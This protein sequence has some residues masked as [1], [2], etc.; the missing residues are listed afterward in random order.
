MLVKPLRHKARCLVRVFILKKIVYTQLVSVNNIST[1]YNIISNISLE[2]SAVVVDKNILS[3]G[4]SRK[5]IRSL[6]KQQFY[7]FGTSTTLHGLRYVTDKRL[8][9]VEK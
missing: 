4:E 9:I 7:D 2:Q 6:L 5:R 8:S 1:Y 3:K